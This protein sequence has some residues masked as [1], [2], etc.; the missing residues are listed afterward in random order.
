LTLRRTIVLESLPGR[1]TRVALDKTA[2][3]LAAIDSGG[4]VALFDVTTGHEIRHWSITD[5][6]PGL[7][8]IVSDDARKLAVRAENGTV[9]V[10]DAAR[11]SP[12]G[13][14]VARVSAIA[15]NPDGS[16]LATAGPGVQ[17]WSTTSPLEAIG[18]PLDTDLPTDPSIAATL[19]APD[20]PNVLQFALDGK[21]LLELQPG[22][23]PHTFD[24]RSVEVDAQS[25][26]D[27]ACSIAAR[28]LTLPERQ[29]FDPGNRL[30]VPICG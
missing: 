20:T 6:R 14:V 17:L 1:L 11:A 19:A 10:F 29:R 12:I 23:F 24:L 8:L 26:A 21:N 13:T 3:H 9:W 2:E 27:S 22:P 5:T 15:F 28:D 16:L 25:L 4:R 7:R 18:D 30:P